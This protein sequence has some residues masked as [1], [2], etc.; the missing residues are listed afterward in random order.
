MTG[1]EPNEVLYYG[2][3]F[4]KD[5]IK[6]VETTEV[7]VPGGTLINYNIRLKNNCVVTVFQDCKEENIKRGAI[8]GLFESPRG[9]K[10]MCNNLYSGSIK[11]VDGQT[12]NISLF[13]C[14]TSVDLGDYNSS[15][16]YDR[17][18]IDDL[19]EKPFNNWF[20]LNKE[21]IIN[22]LKVQPAAVHNDIP[23]NESGKCDPEHK[24][25]HNG[26]LY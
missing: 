14:E 10:L 15:K 20:N 5:D 1:I 12:D 7:A 24:N 22:G 18:Y 2:V 23:I 21:D 17:L 3:K 19:K 25:W 6:N 26:L 4:Y 16:D 9:C 13:N 11:G 8:V